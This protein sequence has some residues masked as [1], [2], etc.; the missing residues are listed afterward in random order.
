[1][2]VK[3]GASIYII[4]SFAHVAS[5]APIPFV[6]PKM[7]AKGMH[8]TSSRFETKS[9]QGS[10]NLILKETRHPCL[11]VQDDVNFI[12]NDVEMVKGMSNMPSIPT[13]GT[14]LY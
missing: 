1:M 2:R 14:K 8:L 5:I 3:S 12:P 9:F 11:E 7:S 4:P 10:G 6:K 13:I